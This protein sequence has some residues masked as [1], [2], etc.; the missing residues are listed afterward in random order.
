M[1]RE[2][3][4]QR[5]VEQIK[6]SL[7][8]HIGKSCLLAENIASD[9]IDNEVIVPPCKVGD[10]VYFIYNNNVY[11]L[12]IGKIVSKEEGLF[13]VDKEYN[14]WYSTEELGKTLYL[15]EEEAE[16]QRLVELLNEATDK[17]GIYLDK[18]ADYLLDNGV[19]APPVKVG[20]KFY[21]IETWCTEGGFLEEPIRPYSSTCEHCCEECDGKKKVE[22]YTFNSII[23][24]LEL[25]R[26]F[27]K[28]VYLTREEAEAKLKRKEDGNEF[29]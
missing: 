20:D 28:S 26:Y 24:I 22:E 29:I 25:E 10:K 16:R 14:G 11:N 7:N 2:S 15:S 1:N 17:H 18:V 12:T 23:Q 9:L 5:L 13:L 27:G 4:R 3:E 6:E 8:K 21:R 19:I